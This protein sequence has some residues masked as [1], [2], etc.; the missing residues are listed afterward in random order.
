MV[1]RVT[2]T[3]EW[4]VKGG[5]SLHQWLAAEHATSLRQ[6]IAEMR[7]PPPPMDRAPDPDLEAFFIQ[8]G[9]A[10]NT[11]ELLTGLYD[12]VLPA[13]AAGYDQY[14]RV[15]NPL[16]DHPSRR[17]IS[18]NLLEIEN[19]EAWGRT[20]L[21]AMGG[22]MA[23][24]ADHLRQTLSAVGGILGAEDRRRAPRPQP[25]PA[26]QPDFTP[27][28][29]ERFRGQY[30]FNFPPHVLYNATNLDAEERNLAL[31]C[32]RLLEMDV[33]EMMAS[34][35]AERTDQPSD[36]YRDYGRQLWDEARHSMMGEVAFEARGVDWKDIPLNIGFALRLN[37]H[38][39]PVER[40]LLLW[41]IE[42]SLMPG[43]TGKRSEYET[44]VEAGD[45]LSMHFH[46]YDWADEVLHA[47]IGRHWLLAEDGESFSF[48]GAMERGKAVHD[49]TWPELVR[50]R[51]EVADTDWWPRFVLQVLGRMS[52][53]TPD[54]LVE[55]PTVVSE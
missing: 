40:Q 47:Q 8:V 53:A 4:E 14:L 30:D 22:P 20:A 32:K 3:P 15:S 34:F 41:A 25:R 42:Q 48:K 26:W 35:V 5:L 27:R 49:A 10:E 33:P 24:F 43:E 23:H 38:A 18:I 6:R 2:S 39:T 44:A 1:E 45:E 31:L 19:A 55:D 28:R 11:Q 9:A 51:G 12:V 50:Y 36:F 21:T 46:D 17:V 54:Q 7:S 52:Q 37:L 29:D 16:V 13:L